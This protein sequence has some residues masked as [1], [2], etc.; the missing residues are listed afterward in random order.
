MDF[1]GFCL[2]NGDGSAHVAPIAQNEKC[3]EYTFL[4]GNLWFLVVQEWQGV[5][6]WAVIFY[7]PLAQITYF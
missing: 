7:W 3:T 2:R 4:N 1:E 5:R 6:I